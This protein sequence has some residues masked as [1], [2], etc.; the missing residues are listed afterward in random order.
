[1]GAVRAP[2]GRAA[3]RA[4]RTGSGD[5][6]LFDPQLDP[7]AVLQAA[8]PGGDPQLSSPALESTSDL[9]HRVAWPSHQ[10]FMIYGSYIHVTYMSYDQI[11]RLQHMTYMSYVHVTYRSYDQIT[12]L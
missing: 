8:H 2:S 5:P 9:S 3:R 1:M 11:T 6:L 10:V 4:N 7:L 12:R